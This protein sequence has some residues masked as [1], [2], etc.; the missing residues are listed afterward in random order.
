[1]N[2]GPDFT[3]AECAILLKL[4]EAAEDALV[5]YWEQDPVARSRNVIKRDRLRPIHD[6]LELHARKAITI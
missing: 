2:P 5:D 3:P 6:K 4:V 1:M